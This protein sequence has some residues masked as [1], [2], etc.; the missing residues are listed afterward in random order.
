MSQLKNDFSINVCASNITMI[1]SSL[2]N[3]QSTQG[4]STQGSST[5]GSST[6]FLSNKEVINFINGTWVPPSISSVLE[7]SIQPTFLDR[8]H[9][10][11]LSVKTLSKLTPSAIKA[12]EDIWG[13]EMV[14][15]YTNNKVRKQWTTIF[16]ESIAK[17]L[18][19]SNGSLL[20][21]PTKVAK[22]RPDFETENEVIEVKTGTYWTSGTAH[23]KIAGVPYKYSE[24]PII[25]G[26]PLKIV[27]IGRAE[28]EAWKSGLFGGEYCTERHR[29]QIDLWKQWQIYIVPASSLLQPVEQT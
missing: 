9:D 2:H 4:S 6:R 27:C 20:I 12:E 5:Q 7:P 29:E 14:R 24:I 13:K 1:S 10:T 18:Y 3:H 26:K 17:E 25:Y 15:K 19:T 11:R 23:E 22:F 21:T 16:G 8:C 28:E